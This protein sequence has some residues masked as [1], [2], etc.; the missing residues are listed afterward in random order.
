VRVEEDIMVMGKGGGFRQLSATVVIALLLLIFSGCVV[1]KNEVSPDVPPIPTDGS[2]TL[3]ATLK[4]EGTN[5]SGSGTAHFRLNPEQREICYTIGVSGI[6]L[7]AT[8]AHIHRG[9]AGVHGPIVVRLMSPNAQGVAVACAQASRDL[10]VAIMQHPADFYVNV[11]N[12]HYPE[13]AVRGQL[14]AC[15]PGSGC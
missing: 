9:A 10:I 2:G 15:G 14:S 13:G 6:E 8:A 11:H 3:V 7:P 12:A 4:P 1:P 5:T